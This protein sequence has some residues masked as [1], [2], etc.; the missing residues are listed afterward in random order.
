MGCRSD[1]ME[2][3]EREI[4]SVRVAEHMLYL[5]SFIGIE[6]GDEMYLRSVANSTYGDV[7]SLDSMTRDLCKTLRTLDGTDDG[8]K[9]IYNGRNPKARKLA[10]WWDEHQ[11]ADAKRERAETEAQKKE[12]LKK[13]A[14]A[15]LTKEELQALGLD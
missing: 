4:E 3:D 6:F 14:I 2:P 7:V 9:I 11:D 1:Y 5:Q 8:E 12:K 13:S 10:D 15:K